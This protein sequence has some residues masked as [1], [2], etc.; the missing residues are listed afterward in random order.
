MF[1]FTG[2]DAKCQRAKRAVRGSMAITA[3]NRLSGLRNTQLRPNDVHDALVLAVHV[4]Q[5][6]TG[7]FAV[8]FQRVE[9]RLG[10]LVDDG[11]QAVFGRHRVIHHR[12]REI[13]AAHRAAFGAKTRKR[14]RRRALVN[15]VAVDV[16]QRRFAGFLINDMTVPN[17]FV[18]GLAVIGYRLKFSTGK[19]GQKQYCAVVPIALA[20]GL[21]RS[22]PRQNRQ[23]RSRTMRTQVGHW[24]GFIV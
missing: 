15:Q 1:H 14:L 22:G 2:A 4:K 23:R 16:K 11:Q 5:P 6:H 24:P 20:T 10:I 13:R 9:L 7:F 17:L 8:L 18:E 12:K 21:P 3:N 19:L